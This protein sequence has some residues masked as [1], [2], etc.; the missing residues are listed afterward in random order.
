MSVSSLP[1]TSAAASV[2]GPGLPLVLGN[3][4]LDYPDGG[5]TVKA[6]ANVS[7]GVA[8]GQMVALVGPSGSGKSSL[9][10]VAATLV[11]PTDGQV[12]IDGITT[13][14]LKDAD[15]TALRR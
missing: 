1:V 4:T 10:A 14:D 15:L 8:A 6:L 13:A 3:V 12:V 2:G 11:R 7:L 9:L 5:G